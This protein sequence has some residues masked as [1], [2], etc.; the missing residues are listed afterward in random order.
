MNA[1]YVDELGHRGPPIGIGASRLAARVIAWQ[2]F[3]SLGTAGVLLVLPPFLLLLAGSLAA[4]A[5][6]SIISAVLIAGSPAIGYSWILIR[7]RRQLV[8]SLVVGAAN[9]DQLELPKLNDDPWNIVT[10]WVGCK[11]VALMLAMTVWRPAILPAT[12]ALTLCLLGIVIVAAAALPL[13]VLVRGAFVRVVELAPPDVMRDIIETY[14][15][16]GKLRGRMSRRLIAALVTPVVF[17]TVGSALIASAHLRSADE[18]DREETARAMGRAMLEATPSRGDE[19]GR[20]AAIAA[21]AQLGF[22]AQLD[23]TPGDFRVER[24]RRGLVEVTTA[25]DSGTARVEFSGSTVSGISWPALLVAVFAVA[26]AGSIGV[27]LGRLLSR[28][29]RMANHGVRLLGT[30]AALEGT[31]VMKPARFRAVAE[32]GNAIE[33]LAS[34]FRLFA[35]A[36]ERAIEARQ[37]ATRTR[38]LFFASVS[39]DL[40]SPLNAI[41]G[42]AELARRGEVLTEGQRESL[43]LIIQRGHELL[44]LIE[45]ILDAARVEAGQLTLVRT[46]ES[47]GEL[48]QLAIEKG[49]D[50]SSD[51]DVIVL[52][53][54]PEGTPKLWVDRVR[55]SQ[56]LATFVGHA[57]RTAER[58]SLR[59]R[60]ESDDVGDKPTLARRRIRIHIE[61]PSARFSA[62]DLEAMLNPEQQPGQHRGLALALRLA[63]AI[64]ELHGGRVKMA[65]RTVREPAFTVLLYTKPGA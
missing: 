5:T 39:H 48:L 23:P 50:L 25:L 49:K 35:Q 34:R 31:R 65:G 47:I 53:E 63:K 58:P 62:H 43:D 52:A 4:R 28:D 51:S 42:F 29:L 61:V 7:R 32:L 46:E 1:S 18:L 60:V 2:V 11:V 38:G 19:A 12:T 8:R 24:G 17:L 57:R 41:L 55:L 10:F 14:E 3:F 33:L 45:T 9:V 56:A 37:A 30:D 27:G 20:N 59:I 6:E 44:A 15:R 36:Q 21:A 40:K 26:A 54:V 64:V 22:R 16:T 13:L